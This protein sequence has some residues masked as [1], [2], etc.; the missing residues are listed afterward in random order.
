ML[1]EIEDCYASAREIY[2]IARLGTYGMYNSTR[3]GDGRYIVN[4]P[5]VAELYRQLGSVK[6]VR[7]QTG[8]D[9]ETIRHCLKEAGIPI[10]SGSQHAKECSAIPTRV[11]D[12]D[13][14]YNDFPSRQKAAEYISLRS[15]TSIRSIIAHI[16]DAIA[17]KRK[18]VCGFR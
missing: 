17:G 18:T 8:Y 9:D 13:G 15:G 5:L 14:V 1:E 16:P 10:K 2:W 12:G 3:G 4:K 7:N 6:R 11:I